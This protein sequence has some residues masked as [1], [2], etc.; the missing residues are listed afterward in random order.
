MVLTPVLKTGWPA[1][2]F[3]FNSYIFRQGIKM[4]ELD[5]YKA[6]FDVMENALMK[7]ADYT[8]WVEE[9]HEDCCDCHCPRYRNVFQVD[10]ED[11]EITAEYALLEVSKL[12][13]SK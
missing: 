11:G 6:A 2:R 4:T 1:K 13:E 3:G 9:S 12:M 8:K 10:W 5:K 7:Y